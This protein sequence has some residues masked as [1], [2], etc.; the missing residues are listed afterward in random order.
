MDVAHAVTS[1]HALLMLVR[2][3]GPGTKEELAV[4]RTEM[5]GKLGEVQ[6]TV[7]ELQTARQQITELEEQI[8]RS[9][10]WAGE[11]ERYTLKELGP[12]ALVYAAK[13]ALQ[14][15]GPAYALC[16][17]CYDNEQRSTLQFADYESSLR[18]FECPR[19][20]NRVRYRDPS[21]SFEVRTVPGTLN[22]DGF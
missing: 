21:D 11:R 20:K 1:L 22:V 14:G 19:C 13:D 15:D 6:Q 3:L 9:R 18:V 4:A 8:N 5:L 2:D 10:D 7:L 12:G 17:H 16:A